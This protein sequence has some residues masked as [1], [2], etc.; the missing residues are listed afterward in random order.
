MLHGSFSVTMSASPFTQPD[1]INSSN[2]RSIALPTPVS[3]CLFPG[4][5]ANT[6]EEIAEAA[7]WSCSECS[8]FLLRLWREE[9]AGAPTAWHGEIDPIQAGQK[10]GFAD[11]KTMC[12]LLQPQVLGEPAKESDQENG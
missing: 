10:R 1:L 4:R 6:P 7:V 9:E 3:S 12:D 5:S 8:L 2:C 11:L